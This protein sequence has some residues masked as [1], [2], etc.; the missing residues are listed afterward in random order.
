MRGNLPV[1]SCPGL[2]AL[3]ENLLLA[4]Q[5]SER[6]DVSNDQ[7]DAELV[8]RADLPEGQAA[9]LERDS[10]AGAVVADLHQLIL[11]DP[12]LEVVA[13]TKGGIPTAAVQVAVSQLRTNL[14]RERLQNAGIVDGEMRHRKINVL[15]RAN[16]QQ[17]ARSRE[18][19]AHG[20]VLEPN[21]RVV[22]PA[23][24]YAG[25]AIDRRKAAWLFSKGKR[26]DGIKR[27]K[28]VASPGNERAVER[29]IEVVFLRH[30]PTDKLV[31]L[32][33]FSAAEQ[34]LCDRIHEFIRVRQ[35]F[36]FIKANKAVELIHAAH[37]VVGDFRIDR[38]L[39]FSGPAFPD[40]LERRRP[41]Q[42]HDDARR[43]FRALDGRGSNDSRYY[44][45]CSRR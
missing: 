7:S 21:L 32:A 30:A 37:V 17:S 28:D 22:G 25:I 42:R 13:E 34:P 44:G 16:F 20:V 35:G 43:D 31:G 45:L 10:A 14:I 29:G 11:Q 6:S 18:S 41:V 26:R 40:A 8:L 39:P 9:I 5:I 23:G 27:L 1:S 38:V 19:V 24:R 12:L 3:L 2:R 33:A 36:V 15:I 4:P